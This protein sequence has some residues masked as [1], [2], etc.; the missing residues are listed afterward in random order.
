[1]REFRSF[2]NAEEG[3]RFPAQFRLRCGGLSSV[4]SGV[5]D[6]VIAVVVVFL[7]LLLLLP[8]LLPCSLASSGDPS[9]L[10]RSFSIIDSVSSGSWSGA[11]RALLDSGI[12]MALEETEWDREARC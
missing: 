2:R 4:T 12:A 5:F 6:L 10:A 3:T 11:V 7:L 8:L 9:I 1:L